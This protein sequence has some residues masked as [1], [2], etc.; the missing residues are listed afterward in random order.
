MLMVK[1][2]GVKSIFSIFIYL[3]IEK[4][5]VGKKTDILPNDGLMVIYHGRK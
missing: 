4:N 5:V 3:R 2:P 1:M